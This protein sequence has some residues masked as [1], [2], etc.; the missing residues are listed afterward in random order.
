MYD[1]LSLGLSIGLGISLD[2]SVSET[3][4]RQSSDTS[5]FMCLTAEKTSKCEICHRVYHCPDHLEQHGSCYP[6]RV[7]YD[8]EVGRYLEAT[9]DIKQGEIIFRDSP[10]VVGP[11]KK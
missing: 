2:I 5:C 1:L 7:R 11:S 4:S 3:M 9:R 10:T 8:C 6:F